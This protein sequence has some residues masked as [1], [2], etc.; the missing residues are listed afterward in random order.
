MSLFSFKTK[1]NKNKIL[2]YLISVGSLV[3][4]GFILIG[5]INDDFGLVGPE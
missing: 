3:F 2:P 5:V 4:I 1:I